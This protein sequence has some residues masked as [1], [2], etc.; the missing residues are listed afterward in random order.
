MKFSLWDSVGS[1]CLQLFLLST[2]SLMDENVQVAAVFK[3]SKS[4]DVDNNN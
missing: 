4:G 2:G 3:L 1:L